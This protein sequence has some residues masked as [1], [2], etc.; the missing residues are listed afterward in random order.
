MLGSAP[1][2]PIPVAFTPFAVG[3]DLYSQYQHVRV[4]TL[5]LAMTL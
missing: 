2:S 3:S 5:R 4:A 1:G